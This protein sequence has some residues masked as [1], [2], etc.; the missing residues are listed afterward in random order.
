ME[1]IKNKKIPPRFDDTTI[2]GFPSYGEW[3]ELYRHL[4]PALV[5]SL[6]K[7]Y[8]YADREDAVEE[9]FHKLMHR[10]DRKAYGEKMPQTEEGW[11][12]QLRW[13]ARSF[14]SHMKDHADRHAKYVESA[15]K[16]M[17][18]MV[19]AVQG[20]NIDDEETRLAL[21]Q[22]LETLCREQDISRRDI[23][24][25][26]RIALKKES[27]KSVS[28]RFHVTENNVYQIKFRIKNLIQKHGPDCFR[29]AL[30]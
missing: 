27:A 24:I 18:G 8:P 26:S 29:R 30:R 3:S 19:A 15:A 6:S 13:Q 20:L 2:I 9:A 10:K 14:L 21:A 22:A 28:K 16:D 23:C 5:N 12:W 7:G 17:L 25:Y 4:Q 1:I 11:F